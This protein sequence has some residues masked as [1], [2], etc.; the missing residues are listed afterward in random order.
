MPV[1]PLIEQGV[2]DVLLLLHEFLALFEPVALALNVDHRAVMEHT[3]QDRRGDR[4][5]GKDLVPLRE[6]FVR[7]EDCRDLLVPPGDELKEQVRA[8]YVHRQIADSSMM[9]SL[10]LPRILSFFGSKFS[11]CAFLSCSIKV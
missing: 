9:S 7:G 1:L 11:K 4:Y 8:L 2:D 3:V 10:Y 5:V 6:G